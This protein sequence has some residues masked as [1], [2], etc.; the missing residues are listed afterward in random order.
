MLKVEFEG[1]DGAGKTTGL[2]YFIEKA[3]QH[4]LKVVETREVGNPN[5]PICVKLR[6]LVLSPDSGL[7][8]ESMEFIF[9]AMRIENDKWMKNLQASTDAPDL[10]VSD[11][12]WLS[13]LAYT[14]NNVSEEFTT[15]LYANLVEN[16]TVKP[17]VVIYFKVNTDTALARRVKR[18]ETMDV[19]E[20]KG[21]PFQEAVRASFEKYLDK[22]SYGNM[23]IFEIDANDTL[24]NVKKQLDFVF[25]SIAHLFL[26]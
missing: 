8:G 7:S 20:M 18:G 26:A 24:D 9:S 21:V 13:H 11:R 12:G 15:K 17:D 25:N 2:K 1:T 19:I 6:E 14:D 3:G 5:I 4:G 22:Y 10:L 23:N 16:I